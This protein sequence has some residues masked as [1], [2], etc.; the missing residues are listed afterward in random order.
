MRHITKGAEPAEFAAWKSLANAQWQPTYRDLQNPQKEAVHGALLT[1]QAGRCCYCGRHIDESDSH[2][3]H[4][5][6]QHLAPDRQLD[7]ANLHASCIRDARATS[8][9]HCGHKKGDAFDAALMIAPADPD[10]ANRFSYAYDG[11]ILE[12]D[13]TDQSATYMI[14]VLNLNAAFLRNRRGEA[15]RRVFDPDFLDTA[16]QEEMRR[17]ALAFHAEESSASG[18]SF[19]H[20]LS[21]FAKQVL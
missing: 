19:P 18:T 5:E 7:F 11:A 15:I 10:C 3:E 16:S 4:F 20:V 1:E 9:L 13:S 17:L 6:P 8:E 12:A 21:R 14:K 2:I